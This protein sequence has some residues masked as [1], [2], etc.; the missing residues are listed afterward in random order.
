MSIEQLSKQL[1]QTQNE[2]S[3]DKDYFS[4]QIS[5]TQDLV[6]NNP[7]I[8]KYLESLKIPVSINNIRAATGQLSQIR[9]SI[10]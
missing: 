2:A 8:I 7:D 4:E 6:E 10:N 9:T 3:L 5:K 1:K